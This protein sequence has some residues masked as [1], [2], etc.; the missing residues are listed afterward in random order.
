MMQRQSYDC[1]LLDLKMPGLSGQRLYE[2]IES[3]DKA[4]AKGIV[5][6]TGDTVS[7]DTRKFIASSGN[8][9]LS[10][11]LELRELGEK[12]GRCVTMAEGYRG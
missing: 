8:P 6:I 3:L 11:P 4:L 12:V 5:F 1:E 2:R 9:A 7:E 10:K